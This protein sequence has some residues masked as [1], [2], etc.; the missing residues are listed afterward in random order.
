M[1]GFVPHLGS[2]IMPLACDVNG[3]GKDEIVISNK[4]GVYCIAHNDGKP[5]VLWKY[6]AADCGPAVVADI[7]ADGFVEVIAATQQGKI[8]VIDK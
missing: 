6:L 8:L 1:P 2:G 7:D 4:T 5:S 3:D